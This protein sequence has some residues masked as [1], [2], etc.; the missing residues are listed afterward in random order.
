MWIRYFQPPFR[1]QKTKGGF[2]DTPKLYVFVWSALSVSS[3]VVTTVPAS[4]KFKLLYS[5]HR[6]SFVSFPQQRDHFP[7]EF[8]NLILCNWDGVGLLR[9]TN[10]TLHII[11]VE[12]SHHRLDAIL[13]PVRAVWLA[14]DSYTGLQLRNNQNEP[15]FRT[16][17][18]V[19]SR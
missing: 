2:W 8:S 1:P 7:T 4:F 18:R 5:A 19:I 13:H 16:R 17:W 12:V 6:T 10:R 11:L 15:L 9:G 14:D 3:P